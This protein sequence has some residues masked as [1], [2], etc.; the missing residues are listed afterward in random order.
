MRTHF[1]IDTTTGLISACGRGKRIDLNVYRVDCGLCK[2]KAM[3][4]DAHAAAETEREAAFMRQEPRIIPEPW[5]DGHLVCRNCGGDQF[6]VGDRTCYGHYQDYVC[7]GCGNKESR[8]T[9]TG[10]SF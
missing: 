4:I 9:E 2:Q 8:L 3:F 7:A 6:R 1:A 10:M 5:R